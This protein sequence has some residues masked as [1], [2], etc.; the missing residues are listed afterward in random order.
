VALMFLYTHSPNLYITEA[1][2]K[3]ARAMR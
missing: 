3:V 1:L 2:R